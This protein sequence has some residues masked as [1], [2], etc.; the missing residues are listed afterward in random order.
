MTDKIS[1]AELCKQLKI[2][3]K[4][5]RVRLRAA[6]VKHEGRYEFTAAQ[7]PK[8]KAIIKGDDEAPKAAAKAKAPAKKKSAAKTADNAQ[9][10]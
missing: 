3:G 8:I 4:Q 2:P 6:S 7:L 5:A 9:A 10:A 1:L